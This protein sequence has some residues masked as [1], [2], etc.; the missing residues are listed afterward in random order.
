MT[1]PPSAFLPP[2]RWLVLYL[3]SSVH[4]H[5]III[6]PLQGHFSKVWEE[7]LIRKFLGRFLRLVFCWREKRKRRWAEGTHSAAFL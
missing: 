5:E 3:F 1:M 4:P 6:F 2:K 7:T